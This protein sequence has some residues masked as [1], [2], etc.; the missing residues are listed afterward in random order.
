MRRAG[1]DGMEAMLMLNQLRWL[2]H[3]R[4][5]GDDRI[6]KQLMYGQVKSGRRNPGGQKRRYQDVVQ[7]S[8]SRHNI[9]F[10][11]W[12]DLALN[13]TAWRNTVRAGVRAFNE[14]LLRGRERKRA[15]RK[16]TIGAIGRGDV[17]IWRCDVCGRECA[18]REPFCTDT[19]H[20]VAHAVDSIPV[21]GTSAA[22]LL[23]RPVE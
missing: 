21:T 17:T 20:C 5:L 11:C 13:R 1:T 6:P 2:G 23:E 14:Q 9:E 4:R 3:V 18:G 10:R 8:L 15:V 22:A 16:G 12:E 19:P 7:V